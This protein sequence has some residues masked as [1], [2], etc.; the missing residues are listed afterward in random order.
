MVGELTIIKGPT[1]DF[2][3]HIGGTPTLIFIFR[4]I[5]VNSWYTNPK[6]WLVYVIADIQEASSITYTFERR[7]FVSLSDKGPL[8]QTLDHD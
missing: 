7:S 1:L 3:I 8:P 4:F 6:I 2:T 5:L